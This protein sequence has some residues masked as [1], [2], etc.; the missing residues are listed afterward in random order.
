[1]LAPR[2]F[3]LAV[4]VPCLFSLGASGAANDAEA[5]P[6]LPGDPAEG[7]SRFFELTLHPEADFSSFEEIHLEP[8]RFGYRDEEAP[9]RARSSSL[10]SSAGNR[11][12]ISAEGR[13]EFERIFNEALIAE[14]GRGKQFRLTESIGASTLTLRTAVLNIVS[15]YPPEPVGVTEVYLATAGYATVLWEV[16]DPSSGE[17][18][19]SMVIRN[20]I[21]SGMERID[22]FTAPSNRSTVRGDVRR[23]TE[24]NTRRLRRELDDQF[25]K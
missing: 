2:M 10:N 20:D 9:S 17:V 19:L 23:W 25:S 4:L 16:I 11:Q 5:P 3:F 14:L 21:G 24:N 6:D 12:G 18:L 7:R 1:M 15:F 22:R 13:A 8:A